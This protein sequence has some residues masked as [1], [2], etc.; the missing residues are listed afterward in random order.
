[1]MKLIRGAQK[2]IKKFTKRRDI[3]EI[4]VPYVMK[5]EVIKDVPLA[6]IV[7]FFFFDNHCSSIM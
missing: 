1:M 5:C 3:K 7:Q 6:V 4:R 2:S